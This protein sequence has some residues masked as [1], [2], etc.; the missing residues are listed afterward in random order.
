MKR[1]YKDDK[2]NLVFVSCGIS[3][4]N[5]WMTVKQKS[6]KV[7]TKRLVSNAL[8]LR[9]TEA[10]AQADLDNYAISKGWKIQNS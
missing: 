10:E 2:E 8:P 7:G 9:N 6:G 5:V 1:L 4:G 3:D